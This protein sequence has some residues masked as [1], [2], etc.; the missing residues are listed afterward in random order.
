M[1]SPIDGVALS[2][3][4]QVAFNDRKPSPRLAVSPLFAPTVDVAVIVPFLFDHVQVEPVTAQI[5]STT[6]NVLAADAEIFDA[7]SVTT[8]L[9]RT[10]TSVGVNVADP[11]R[12]PA[13]F[14]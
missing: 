11:T 12:S 1:P 14:V 3:I 9:S 6:S 8:M 7:V 5:F 2:A 13:L 10:S 4:V